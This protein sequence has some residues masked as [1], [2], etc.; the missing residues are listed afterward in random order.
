MGA[1][2]PHSERET[3]PVRLRPIFDA[4]YVWLLEVN[5]L[6]MDVRYAPREVQ[7]E[8]LRRGFIPYLPKTSAAW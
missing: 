4:I 6:L 7:E 2:A 5:G 3:V 8:A 1:L